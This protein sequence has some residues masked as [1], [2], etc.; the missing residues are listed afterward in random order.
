M[1]KL[2]KRFAEAVEPQ[3]EGHVVWDDAYP[4]SVFASIPRAS[5]ATSSSTG[6]V[7]DRVATR[8]AFMAAILLKN[9]RKTASR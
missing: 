8:S 6:L 4:A 9:A 2:T 7:V 3:S 1:A 5:A